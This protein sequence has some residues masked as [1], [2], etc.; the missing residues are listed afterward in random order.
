MWELN[1]WQVSTTAQELELKSFGIHFSHPN[2]NISHVTI[3]VSFLL[4]GYRIQCINENA[5][6]G[7]IL[8]AT[9]TTVLQ[10]DGKL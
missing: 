6:L 9:P 4:N 1:E 5:E 8:E 2:Q 10:F 7:L 3:T